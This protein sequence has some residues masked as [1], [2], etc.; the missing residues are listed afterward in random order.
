MFRLPLYVVT[1]S[2]IFAFH[3]R[4]SFAV[5][6]FAHFEF[7]HWFLTSFGGE[8]CEAS[9]SSPKHH[10][11]TSMSTHANALSQIDFIT[12]FRIRPNRAKPGDLFRKKMTKGNL[13]HTD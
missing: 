6:K 4:L 12:K 2:R 1:N 3:T 11:Y 9:Q 5:S 10:H 13:I 7:T 8:N